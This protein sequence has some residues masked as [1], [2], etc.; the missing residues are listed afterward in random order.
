[1]EN[2]SNAATAQTLSNSRKHVIWFTLLVKL[3]VNFQTFTIEFKKLR[4]ELRKQQDKIHGYVPDWKELL[5]NFSKILS[6][7]S[8]VEQSEMRLFIKE[9]AKDHLQKRVKPIELEEGKK[10]EIMYEL[11]LNIPSATGANTV[12]HAQGL[13]KKDFEQEQ[14]MFE[15]KPATLFRK[16]EEATDYLAS[17]MSKMIGCK[18]EELQSAQLAL[19]FAII[20]E[21]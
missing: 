14:K 17:E 12:I 5:D 13:L 20:D 8:K 2:S 4:N 7:I 11:C 15:S 1:M 21:I 19:I 10:E 18:P 3:I 16:I 9:Y 6:D